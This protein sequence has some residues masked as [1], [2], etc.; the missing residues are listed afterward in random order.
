M[1][2]PFGLA[3]GRQAFAGLSPLH[4]VWKPGG[5]AEMI[6]ASQTVWFLIP[7]NTISR[8]IL[9]FVVDQA[10]IHRYPMAATAPKGPKHHNPEDTR[11]FD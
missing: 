3:T 7:F 9:S 4:M 11:H 6:R 5:G 10:H 8:Q 1:I 2:V